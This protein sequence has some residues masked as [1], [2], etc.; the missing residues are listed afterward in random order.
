MGRLQHGRRS[1]QEQEMA[2]SDRLQHG[3]T[4]PALGPVSSHVAEAD[5]PDII[6][7]CRRSRRT[8]TIRRLRTAR[9]WRSTRR[10]KSTKQRTF[11][12]TS[13]RPVS[14]YLHP[15]YRRAWFCADLSLTCLDP[16][17]SV[18]QLIRQIEQE[19]KARSNKADSTFRGTPPRFAGSAKRRG[20]AD[21]V[22]T[23]LHRH[24][25]QQ[26]C[27]LPPASGGAGSCPGRLIGRPFPALVR[28][29]SLAASSQS[30]LPVCDPD[31]LSSLLNPS[32]LQPSPCSSSLPSVLLPVFLSPRYPAAGQP[33][34]LLVLYRHGLLL[35]VELRFCQ[36]GL[37]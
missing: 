7:S 9:R 14:T 8:R 24:V 27:C 3:R 15:P 36:A 19:E 23:S 33:F 37:G 35:N 11:S 4:Y 32:L 31:R 26:S 34:D 1:H 20:L 16:D 17:A 28:H 5:S 10:E 6:W 22:F 18:K 30:G 29:L 21:K 13:T 25:Y 12:T 2:A